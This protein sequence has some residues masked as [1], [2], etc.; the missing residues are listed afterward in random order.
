M[1][2]DKAQESGKRNHR[3]IRTVAAE[4]RSG[5]QITMLLDDTVVAA[6][7]DSGRTPQQIVDILDDLAEEMIGRTG[8]GDA[9]LRQRIAAARE[10]E[11][12]KAA[13]QQ[14]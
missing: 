3:L 10:M 6:N 8:P 7:A 13:S 2:T 5:A 9:E 4:R 12:S 14:R 11:I 1:M